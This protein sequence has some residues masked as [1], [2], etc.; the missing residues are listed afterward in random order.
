MTPLSQS[1]EDAQELNKPLKDS[2]ERK[3]KSWMEEVE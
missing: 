2:R 1:R 3:G